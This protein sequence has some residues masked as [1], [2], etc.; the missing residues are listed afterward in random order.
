MPH[1]ALV[2]LIPSLGNRRSVCLV[3]AAAVDIV[4]TVPHLPVRGNDLDMQAQGIHVGGCALNVAIALKRLGLRST[5]ALPIGTGHWADVIRAALVEKGIASV[6]QVPDGDNGWCVALVEPDGERTFLSVMGV[7]SRWTP[8]LFA[9]LP[10]DEEAIVFVSGY[11][12]SLE[13]GTVLLDWLRTLPA[14]ATV[15][16]DFGPRI[17]AI[18]A[19]IMDGVMALQP[20][21]SLNRQEAAFFGMTGAPEAFATAWVD[22]YDC[23]L[24]LR[25]DRDGA[26]F[27][28]AHGTGHALPFKTSVV[29]T[30]GAGDAHAG[31]TIA[32]LA[33]GWSLADAVL[34][35]NA[36]AA[37]VVGHQGADCAPTTAEITAYLKGC[38]G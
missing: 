27:A 30:I 38:G 20:I 7:E 19:P 28:D 5:N 10:R 24:V 3:G 1:N 17:G 31:G 22:R 15:L 16:V 26:L 25:L 23:P 37:Y 4:T 35:G 21:V 13:G 32:G 14:S 33:S 2:S 29:D 9:T 36:V 12:L 18:P 8:A 6:W 11:Q 34:F